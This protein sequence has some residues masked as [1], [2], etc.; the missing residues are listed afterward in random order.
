VL[1]LQPSDPGERFFAPAFGIRAKSLPYDALDFASPCFPTLIS[2]Y[3][4]IDKYCLNRINS[5]SFEQF[6][7]AFW[8]FI[9]PP[10]ALVIAKKVTGMPVFD[11]AVEQ[12][13]SGTPDSILVFFS[14]K[15]CV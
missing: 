12:H 14:V 10:D 4:K 1:H 11:H 3:T 6:F 9:G 7:V 8:S 13:S 2:I 15:I 5:S